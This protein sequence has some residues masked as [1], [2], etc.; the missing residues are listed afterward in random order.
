MVDI[1]QIKNHMVNYFSDMQLDDDDYYDE[2]G[3]CGGQLLTEIKEF[4][5]RFSTNKDFIYVVS[6]SWASDDLNLDGG[7]DYFF[8]S[9]NVIPMLF[10]YLYNTLGYSFEEYQKCIR[11]SVEL[12]DDIWDM[13]NDPAIIREARIASVLEDKGKI[14]GKIVLKYPAEMK[15]ELDNNPLLK[16]VG[17]SKIDQSPIYSIDLPKEYIIIPEINEI[18]KCE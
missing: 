11:N 17:L 6:G 5:N 8:S 10:D 9:S 18:L 13:Y 12:T 7:R 2:D 14:Q 16:F 4:W 15:F 1:E 3:H